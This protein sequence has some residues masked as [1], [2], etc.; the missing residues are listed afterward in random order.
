LE[1]NKVYHSPDYVLEDRSMG[2]SGNFISIDIY[3]SGSDF[4]SVFFSLNPFVE[5]YGEF[6]AG[7][8]QRAAAKML[9]GE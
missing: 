2:K 1:I 6:K 4:A 5:G 9:N 3:G 7:D 8:F